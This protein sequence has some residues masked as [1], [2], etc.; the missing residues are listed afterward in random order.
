[1]PDQEPA[2]QRLSRRMAIVLIVGNF[3]VMVGGCTLQKQPPL[4]FENL[5]LFMVVG[6]MVMLSAIAVAALDGDDVL[7]IVGIPLSAT[8]A[9][10]LIAINVRLIGLAG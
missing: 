6:T 5:Y 10:A 1:M 9:F 2:N 7:T 3:L 4:W 8:I